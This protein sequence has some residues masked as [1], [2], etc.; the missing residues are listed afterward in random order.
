VVASGCGSNPPCTI[1][2]ATVDAARSRAMDAEQKLENAEAQKDRLREQIE[3]AEAER[4]SLEA[5][6]TELEGRIQEPQP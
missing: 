1:D 6:I 3:A 5:R 2:L 4:A